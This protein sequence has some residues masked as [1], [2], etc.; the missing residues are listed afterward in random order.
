[1][2]A[3]S[4]VARFNPQVTLMRFIHALSAL[5]GVFIAGSSFAQS[6]QPSTMNLDHAALKK[7]GWQFAVRTDAF[8]SD[9]LFD[10]IDRL[11][12]LTVHHLELS[13]GQPLSQEHKD[14]LVSPEMKPPEIDALM[15]KLGQVKMDAV[16]YNAGALPPDEAKLR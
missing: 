6:S 15:A 5:L 9:T 13:Y 12:G 8:G 7:L 3:G 14:W 11:H 4:V 16:T 2:A 10:V 1:M